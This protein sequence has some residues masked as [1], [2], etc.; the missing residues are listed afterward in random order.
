MQGEEA[1]P[2]AVVVSPEGSPVAPLGKGI[3]VS[4]TGVVASL[5]DPEVPVSVLGVVLSGAAPPVVPSLGPAVPSELS[6]SDGG[7]IGVFEGGK[8][9]NGVDPEDSEVAGG[10]DCGASVLPVGVEPSGVVPA[11]DSEGGGDP[12]LGNG[13]GVA[14]GGTVATV[15]SVSPDAVLGCSLAELA[16]LGSGAPVLPEGEG[17]SPEGAR[18]A[19]VGAGGGCGY[20]L[21]GG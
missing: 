7:G 20:G 13:I 17:V 3:G 12:S 19:E 11:L 5:A 16:P 21:G 14:I 10:D 9:V 6:E 15:P 2:P 4:A 8:T 1:I 18:V